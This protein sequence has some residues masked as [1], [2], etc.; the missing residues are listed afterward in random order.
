VREG[1]TAGTRNSASRGEKIPFMRREETPS[2][3]KKK[4]RSAR[5]ERKGVLNWKKKRKDIFTTSG[6]AG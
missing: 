6:F 4:I 1:K 2:K 3:S 5:Y